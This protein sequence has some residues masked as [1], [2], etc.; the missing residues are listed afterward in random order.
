MAAGYYK[1]KL[2]ERQSKAECCPLTNF[3]KSQQLRKVDGG[4]DEPINIIYMESNVTSPINK[5]SC[6]KKIRK[7]GGS[8]GSI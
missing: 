5:F 4:A 7:K 2:S 8:V 6:Q 3:G 1:I